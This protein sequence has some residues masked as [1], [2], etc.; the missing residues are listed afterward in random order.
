MRSPIRAAL[1]SGRRRPV[2]RGGARPYPRRGDGLEI[3]ELRGYVEGDDPRRIDWAATA[4]AGN[5][6]VRVLLEEHA[7]CFGAIVD[8]SASMNVGRRRSLRAAAAEALDTWADA[9][10]REDRA[11]RIFADD[12]D[13]PRISGNAAASRL[14][15]SREQAAFDIRAA[16]GL[17]RA[18]LPRDA[19]LL[20]ISDFF[21]EPEEEL[22]RDL[23]VHVDATA[24]VARDPWCDGLP[25][26]G[27]VRVRDAES[28]AA[29]TVFLDRAARRRYVD[30]VQR[31]QERV[32][33]QLTECGWRVGV[34]QEEDGAGS[35][36]AA[37]GLGRAAIR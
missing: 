12:V 16:L 14:R 23:A 22:L 19:A 32:L 7:L 33:A 9:L 13:A 35:L 27:F 31:R 2:V 8:T 18:A 30:A 29:R 34:L 36:L 3:S 37:F 4:R 21:P 17:A 25:L 5:L 11:V 6:Q 15:E 26:R 24:L 1:L 20:A 28:G 10:D